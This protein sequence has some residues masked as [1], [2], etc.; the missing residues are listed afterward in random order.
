MAYPARHGN[1]YFCRAA[2]E[3]Q[4]KNI[5]NDQLPIPL[6]KLVIDKE[7]FVRVHERPKFKKKVESKKIK[8]KEEV[9]K[10]EEPAEKE[11]ILNNKRK[12]NMIIIF[13]TNILN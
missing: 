12:Y 9:K 8:P 11:I 6:Y 5:V 10:I 7:A 2:F 1:H 13:F 4:F 3:K